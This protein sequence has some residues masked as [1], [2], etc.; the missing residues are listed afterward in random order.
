M[1]SRRIERQKERT[2][3]HLYR[4]CRRFKHECHAISYHSFRNRSFIISRAEFCQHIAKLMHLSARYRKSL[5]RNQYLS[6]PR[7][8]RNG[9]S[10]HRAYRRR[11]YTGTVHHIS[12]MY[13]ALFRLDNK[14]ILLFRN[15]GN[16]IMQAE[17]CTK[18]PGGQS[19]AIA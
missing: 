10:Q 13:F 15:R 17:L 16:R 14:K 4:H 12:G 6:L 7:G 9:K 11:P 18:F 1:V 2:V 5:L 3:W 8:Y 19:I